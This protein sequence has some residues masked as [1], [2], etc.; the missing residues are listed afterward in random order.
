MI[1]LFLNFF[2]AIAWMML[3]G[4]YTSLSFAIGFTVGFLALRLSQPFGLKT[5][6][7][8]RF[9]AL[10][11]LLI[12]FCYEMVISVARVVWDV[13]TPTHLSD[14]DIVY[15]PLDVR[16]DLEISLLANMVSLTPGSLS[17]DITQDKKH[18]VVHA[19]FAPDHEKVI[20]EIKEGLEKRILEVTRG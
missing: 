5:S 1:Y 2:L 13:V 8:R 7:F 15:I 4:S 12:Y 3:N 16:T 10:L 17:L 19:M 20:R 18:M 14:P 11:S 6:Y 9:T